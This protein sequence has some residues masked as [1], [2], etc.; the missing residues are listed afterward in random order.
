MKNPHVS[1]TEF[2]VL[3]SAL[4]TFVLLVWAINSGYITYYGTGVQFGP[5]F[6]D[7]LYLTEPSMWKAEAHNL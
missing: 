6:V 3:L 4:A 1:T 7:W 2:T 5:V